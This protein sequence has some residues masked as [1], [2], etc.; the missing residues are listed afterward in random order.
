M[1]YRFEKHKKLS[2]LFPLY[3]IISL[4]ALFAL[5]VQMGAQNIEPFAYSTPLPFDEEVTRGVLQNG[6][7]YYIRENSKPENRAYLQLVVNAGSILEDEDQQGLAHFVEHL[8]FNGTEDFEKNEIVDYLESIGMNFGPEL[9][10]YTSFDETVYKLTVPTDD[11]EK[12][13]TGLRILENWAHKLSFV[14]EEIDKE[15]GVVLE[16]LRLGRGAEAR[17][18]DKQYPVLFTGALYAERLPIGQVDTIR[19]ATYDTIKRFYQDWYRPDQMAVIAV[20]DFDKSQIEEYI[21]SYFSWSHPESE[22]RNRPVFD[23]PGHKQTFFAPAADP[24]A[25]YTTVSVYYK[26]DNIPSYTNEDYRNEIVLGLYNMMLNM[27]FSEASKKPGTPFLGAFATFDSLARAEDYF[28]LF[29]VVN[30]NGVARGLEGLMEELSRASRYGFTE[31]ELNRAKLQIQRSVEQAYKERNKTESGMYIQ[32][33]INHFLEDVPVPGITHEYA[34]YT[35]YLPKISLD[36]VEASASPWLQDGSRVVLVNM[37]EKEGLNLPG[38]QELN[39][40][41]TRAESIIPEEYIDT[42]SDKPLL[43]TLPTEG[44][45]VSKKY[46]EGVDATEL[47]LSNGMRVILKSTDFK[48]G[49]VLFGSFSPGGLSILED[50]DFVTGRFASSFQ[51]ESGYGSF[52]RIELDKKLTGTLVEVYPYIGNLVEGVSG[53]SSVE[54]LETA[55]ILI[56]LLFTQPRKDTESSAVYL[57]RL[58]GIIENSMSRPETVF[59]N[60]LQELRSAGHLRERPITPNLLEEI[61]INRSTRIYQSRFM[62]TG[63]STF[64]FVGAFDQEAIIPLIETYLASINTDQKTETWVDRGSGKPDG[65]IEEALYKGIESKSRVALVFNGSYRWSR[66]ENHAIRSMA[67]ALDIRLREAIREDEGG[68]YGISVTP[69]MERY[70]ENKF[71][72][73]ISFGCDPERAEELADQVIEEIENFK[74]GPFD[75]DLLNKVKEAQRRTFETSIKTNSYWLSRI[76]SHYFHGLDPEAI[77]RYPDLVDGLTGENLLKT[78][79]S[80]LDTDKYIRL[81][82]YPQSFQP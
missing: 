57:D 34:L 8:A 63:D 38:V 80:T 44:R 52:G 74:H 26:R 16:E 39:T 41:I 22:V 21:H 36:E 19:N 70:P 35:E 51:H 27:R 20:G 28:L 37:P 79:I 29:A 18:R 43:E 25:A 53:N 66:E 78:A 49:E 82:L 23:V 42:A 45:I 15:R 31:A 59:F 13:V 69:T 65:M 76:Q 33:Y 60:R 67:E 14:E 40:I 5:P 4:I 62:M 55:F 54:D 64:A 77:L 58:R 71:E 17:M 1:V 46:M 2:R 61:D 3:I 75:K 12:L 81:Y 10:A 50:E 11:P 24:E 9:N 47:S 6:L 72:I 48:D 30:E 73:Q 32:E 56:N 7:S 68:T